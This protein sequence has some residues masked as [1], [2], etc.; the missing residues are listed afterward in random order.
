MRFIFHYLSMVVD[1]VRKPLKAYGIDVPVDPLLTD[2]PFSGREFDE[3]K[4]FDEKVQ[5]LSQIDDCILQYLQDI[6]AALTPQ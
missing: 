5:F 6:S 2:L 3:T 1:N 4:S